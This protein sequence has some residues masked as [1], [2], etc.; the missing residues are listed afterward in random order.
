MVLSL[1]VLFLV[2]WL[3]ATLSGAAGF[4]G[5]L[6]LLPL[7][8]HFIGVK[9]AVPVLT[10]AQLFGNGSR[11]WFGWHEL[12]WRPIVYFLV[13]ALPATLAGSYLFVG[14]ASG[15]ITKAV[16]VLLIAVVLYRRLAIRE[17]PLSNGGM[18]LGGALTGFISGVAGSAGPLGAAF[19]LG[20]HLPATA[21]IASEATTAFAMHLTKTVLYNRFALIGRSELAYGVFLG[22]S[23][24]TGSWTGK[25][26]IE[27]LPRKTFV[28]IVE[29]LLILSGLQL[30]LFGG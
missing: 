26:L 9:A 25:R 5:A 2:G 14:I 18:T 4:G 24:I 15:W 1:L 29:G 20:L 23:M 21:Y 17:I 12:H 10:I 16:G 22:A 30:L 13:A 19:F 27:R 8:T 6:L 11:V 3:A 28:Y 7:L